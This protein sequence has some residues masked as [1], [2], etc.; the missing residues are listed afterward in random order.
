MDLTTS[1]LAAAA[2]TTGTRLATAHR[3]TAT[4]RDALSVL[5]HLATFSELPVEAMDIA[6]LAPPRHR[7]AA[8]TPSVATGRAGAAPVQLDAVFRDNARLSEAAAL[9]QRMLPLARDLRMSNL[10]LGLSPEE[11]DDAAPGTVEAA[12]RNL[13]AYRNNLE[14]RLLSRF[15]DACTQDVRCPCSAPLLSSGSPPYPPYPPG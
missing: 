13:L 15:M 1:S 6:P 5:G 12:L 14:N 8:A 2:A 3:V 4:A 11:I 10:R 7:A 9:V